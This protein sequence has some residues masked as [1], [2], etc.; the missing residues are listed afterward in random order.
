MR[1]RLR[2]EV[3]LLAM[4]HLSKPASSA[5]A[6]QTLSAHG[7]V[8]RVTFPA[9]GISRRG[10]ADGRGVGDFAV[11]T[12]IARLPMRFRL[13][14][15]VALLAMVHLSKPASSAQAAQTLSAHGNVTRVTFP[16]EGISRRGASNRRNEID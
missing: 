7:N 14:G 11:A 10:V 6:A 9:E 12:R 3:A 13:R 2:G 1:F 16:A 5:Q 15:E 4:V 8:T